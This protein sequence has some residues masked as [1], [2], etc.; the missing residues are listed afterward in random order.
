NAFPQSIT[1]PVVR[2]RAWTDYAWDAR[3]GGY[4]YTVTKEGGRQFQLRMSRAREILEEAARLP[5]RCPN[6]YG[7]MQE[8]A[9]AQGWDREEYSHLLS[10]AAKAEPNYYYYYANAARFLLPRWYGRPGVWE[11]LAGEAAKRF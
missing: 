7:V 5:V 11:R 1:E 8:V 6:W 2:A 3:G 9:L 4:A 10:E